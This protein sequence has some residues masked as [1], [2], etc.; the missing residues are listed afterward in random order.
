MST[1]ASNTNG[2]NRVISLCFVKGSPSI[3]YGNFLLAVMDNVAIFTIWHFSLKS[4]VI[5]IS[6][7]KKA[8]WSTAETQAAVLD[9]PVALF[10]SSDCVCK[11]KNNWNFLL[12]TFQT[13]SEILTK[14]TLTILAIED[15][16]CS[17]T[18]PLPQSPLGLGADPGGPW[19]LLSK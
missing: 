14:F 15:H 4:N 3:I 5:Q 10:F 17:H 11:L 18:H 1:L 7:C 19:S 12:S 2:Y 13:V 6:H 16:L 8:L 9:L